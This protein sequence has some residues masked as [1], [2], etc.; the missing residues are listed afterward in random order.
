MLN[1]VAQQFHPESYQADREVVHEGDPGDRFYLIARGEVS[2]SVQQ[3]DGA[4]RQIAL[5]RDGDHFGEIALLHNLPRMATVRT[6]CPTI[7]LSV[8]Q[9]QF[10]KLI[11]GAPDLRDALVLEAWT[12]TLGKSLDA[13]KK[14]AQ[15][16]SRSCGFDYFRRHDTLVDRRHAVR[17]GARGLEIASRRAEALAAELGTPLYLYDGARVREQLARLREALSGF[18]RWR[19]YYALKANRFPR[20]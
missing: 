18:A 2:V 16:N 5:L 4:R 10:L 20:Y 8:Q 6:T 14:P 13:M 11:E 12:P 15:P 7:L 3:P 1:S 9:R 17:A 19:I